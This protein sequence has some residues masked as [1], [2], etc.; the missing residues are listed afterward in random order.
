MT[1]ASA[2][3][4]G[5][6]GAEQAALARAGDQASEAAPVDQALFLRIVPA[7]AHGSRQQRAQFANQSVQVHTLAG[8]ARVQ[9]RPVLVQALGPQAG[10][11]SPF[12]VVGGAVDAVHATV[13]IEYTAASG[14]GTGLRCS[15]YRIELHHQRERVALVVGIS[16]RGRGCR[17]LVA[18]L[19]QQRRHAVRDRQCVP[20]VSGLVRALTLETGQVAADHRRDRHARGL[21]QV[22]G[23]LDHRVAGQPR[24]ADLQQRVDEQP[25][26]AFGLAGMVEAQRPSLEAVAQIVRDAGHARRHQ[27]FHAQLLEQFEQQPR[28]RLGRAQATMQRGIRAQQPQRQPV[29]S[30]TKRASVVVPQPRVQMRRVQRQEPTATVQ[31]ACPEVQIRLA[32]ERAD[33]CR[34]EFLDLLLQSGAGAIFEQAHAMLRGACVPRRRGGPINRPARSAPTRRARD[35]SSAGSTRPP[36]GARPRRTCSGT[37]AGTRA[38]GRGIF[39]GSQP[40]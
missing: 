24:A 34:T 23:L 26:R 15:R 28:H 20:G 10:A 17:G 38:T 39:P 37:T 7:F 14:R 18:A 35:R 11:G 19:Q 1:T 13:G 6:L 31:P 30:T 16:A 8:D 9:A 33:R 32:A 12:A 25:A 27:R 4:L 2:T 40:R 5:A 21:E 29:C 22:L 36:P 3:R